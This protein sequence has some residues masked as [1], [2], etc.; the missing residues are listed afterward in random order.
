MVQAGSEHANHLDMATGDKT[1]ESHEEL[2]N[3]LMNLKVLGNDSTSVGTAPTDTSS[4]SSGSGSCQ[5][6]ANITME[7]QCQA[8]MLKV[9]QTMT[10]KMEKLN[11]N[12]DEKK[13]NN[14]DNQNNRH[15]NRKTPD[16]PIFT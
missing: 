14:H 11:K 12:I 2:I 13:G 3:M 15:V 16:S 7:Q 9:L 4:L 10:A 5:Q 1:T 8:E 6:S